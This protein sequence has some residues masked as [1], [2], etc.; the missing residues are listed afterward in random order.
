MIDKCMWCGKTKPEYINYYGE[1][2]C[3]AT[4]EKNLIGEDLALLKKLNEEGK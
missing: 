4:C 3:N 2:F 1:A